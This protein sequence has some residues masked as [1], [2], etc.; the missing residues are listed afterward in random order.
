MQKKYAIRDAFSESFL[1]KVGGYSGKN[2]PHLFVSFDTHKEA[3]DHILD[4]PGL[5][6]GKPVIIVELF[7]I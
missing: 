1:L 5:N 7:I 4:N 3:E 2:D 6:Q